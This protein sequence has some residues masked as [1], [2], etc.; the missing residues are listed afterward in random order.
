MK[1]PP[2]MLPA[3]GWVTAKARPVATAAS[4]AL[5]P[6]FRISRP[7]FEAIGSTDT[8]APC[9]KLT[10]DACGSEEARIMVIV[11]RTTKVKTTLMRLRVFMGRIIRAR[12]NQG[13]D[14]PH[15]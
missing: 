2:P 3:V 15:A 1:P 12:R 14:E 10:V 11:A 7:A 5:P 9:A 4:T 6:F 8:T 13:Y